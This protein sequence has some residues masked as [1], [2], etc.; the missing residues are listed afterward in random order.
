MLED[1]YI[2]LWR[3]I[4]LDDFWPKGKYSILE[5]WIDLIMS[6]NYKDHFWSGILV[7]RGSLI[8]RHR[9]QAKIWGWKK[10]KINWFLNKLKVGHK[11][12][13]VGNSQYTLLKI[14]NYD[15]YNDINFE[16]IGHKSDTSRTRKPVI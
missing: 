16:Q 14:L 9:E 12:E 4:R 7:K 13:V 15:K 8:I 6:A 11:V 2:H 10:S 3:K 5:A 1:G